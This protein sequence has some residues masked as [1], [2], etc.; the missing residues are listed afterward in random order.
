MRELEW[1]E[2]RWREDLCMG[3]ALRCLSNG[4]ARLAP[5]PQQEWNKDYAKETGVL[6]I[7]SPPE[8]GARTSCLV[9]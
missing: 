7:M 6:M 5:S 8:Q 4:R 1:G 2:C 3:S 9:S